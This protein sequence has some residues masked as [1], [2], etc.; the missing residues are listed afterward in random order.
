LGQFKGHSSGVPGG[1]WLVI[2]LGRDIMP[3]NIFTKFDKN[4]MKT[5]W[6]RERKSC[7]RRSPARS[8]GV[9]IIRPV[10]QTGIL[11]LGNEN[12]FLITGVPFKRVPYKQTTVIGNKNFLFQAAIS[13]LIRWQRVTRERT[14]ARGLTA[15]SPFHRP[16]LSPSTVLEDQLFF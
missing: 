1:I 7:G 13:S 5:L 11:K 4:W 2:E 16:S 15:T 9:P 12:K 3:I 14:C 10:F 8:S 6:L